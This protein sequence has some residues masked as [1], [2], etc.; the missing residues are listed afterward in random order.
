VWLGKL[1]GN[2]EVTHPLENGA[3]VAAAD[4][5]EEAAASADLPEEAATATTTVTIRRKPTR[6]SLNMFTR[7]RFVKVITVIVL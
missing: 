3:E 5:P 1:E 4:R 6:K 2:A 7:L